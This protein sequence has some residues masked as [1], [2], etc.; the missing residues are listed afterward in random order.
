MTEDEMLRWHHR[1]SGHEFEQTLGDSEGRGS[2]ACS[3]PWGHRVRRD[4]A[5]E[6][7]PRCQQE[8]NLPPPPPKTTKMSPS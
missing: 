3:S 2:L 8:H 5:T 7:L 4:Q 1:L 6:Q